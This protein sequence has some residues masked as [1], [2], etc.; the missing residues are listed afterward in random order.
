VP[1]DR[2]Y[3]AAHSAPRV[4]ESARAQRI[5]ANPAIEDVTDESWMAAENICGVSDARDDGLP[6]AAAREFVS[7]DSQLDH[8]DQSR[9]R[10]D[11]EAWLRVLLGEDEARGMRTSQVVE[12]FSQLEFL[13]EIESR[14]HVG[15]AHRLE[16]EFLSCAG[17]ELAVRRDA[18][19]RVR[20]GK[21]GCWRPLDEDSI[22]RA[23]PSE[24]SSY[25]GAFLA[26]D[27]VAQTNWVEGCTICAARRNDT[28]FRTVE[29]SGGCCLSGQADPQKVAVIGGK[30]GAVT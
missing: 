6:S 22:A 21:H 24:K 8:R 23:M 9:L 14:A 18:I 28:A 25:Y 10:R 3:D 1:L 2:L 13:P 12:A 29:K 15:E 19:R 16:K 5:L 4:F 20:L 7:G 26:N 30:F 27:D 17:K 11:I